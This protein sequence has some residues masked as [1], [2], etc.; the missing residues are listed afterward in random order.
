MGMRRWTSSS[1]MCVALFIAS[2]YPLVAQNEPQPVP[3]LVNQQVLEL[4]AVTPQA[5][6]TFGW[7]GAGGKLEGLADEFDDLVIGA[8]NEDEPDTPDPILNSG[9]LYVFLDEALERPIDPVK[10]RLVGSTIQGGMQ[11]GRLDVKIG[12][13]RGDDSLGNPRDNCIFAGEPGRDADYPPLSTCVPGA[14]AVEIYDFNN[15]L[16]N[17]MPSTLLAPPVADVAPNE[18]RLFGNYLAIGDITRDG[19]N[20]LIVSAPDTIIHGTCLGRFYV[21][22]GRADFVPVIGPGGQQPYPHPAW[23]RWIGMN[24]PEP[25]AGA[26]WGNTFGYSIAAANFD[27][28]QAVEVL[29]GRPDRTERFKL[30]APNGGS[31]YLFSGKYLH[32]L[33]GGYPPPGEGTVNRVHNPPPPP[34]AINQ[35][36]PE[37]EYFWHEFGKPGTGQGEAPLWND[38]LGWIVGVADVGCPGEGPPDGIPDALVHDEASDFIGNGSPGVPEISGV[39]GL[40]IFFGLGGQHPEIDGTFVDPAYVFLQMPPN[41]DDLGP[42]VSPFNSRVGRAFGGINL[43]NPQSGLVEPGLLYSAPN[44]DWSGLDQV[45]H[46]YLL[47]FPLCPSGPCVD[48]AAT[49]PTL[50]PANAPNAWGP[51]PMFDLGGAAAMGRF[52]NWLV[53]LNYRGWNPLTQGD[54]FVAT[55][56]HAL[57]DGQPDAGKARA[58]IPMLPP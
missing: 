14:G 15:P 49:Y 23:E 41:L 3:D 1:S 9:A 22:E 53:V 50:R 54:Q 18:V 19:I 21:F 28:D 16:F 12:N 48:P 6:A 5:S 55:I 30:N 43:Y 31:F 37:Y 38:G 33:F 35:D 39:G 10:A 26:S 24:P 57:V 51:V 52:A 40:W 58:Y 13:V 42:Q 11:L 8:H 25:H 20:D 32:D 7:T 47:R 27:V 45:G 4:K 29:V 34:D 17:G 2:A 56:R 44:A 36:E 46:L